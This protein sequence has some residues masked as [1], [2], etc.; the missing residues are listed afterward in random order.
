VM[1]RRYMGRV[2]QLEAGR[3]M[4]RYSQI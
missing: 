3:K 2:A 1:T 4:P